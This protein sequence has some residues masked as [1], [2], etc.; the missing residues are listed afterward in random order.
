MFARYERAKA[1]HTN[2]LESFPLFIAAI[3]AGTVVGL[4]DSEMNLVAALILGSRMAYNW[5]YIS[6]EGGALHW[7]RTGVWLGHLLICWWVLVQA[8]LKSM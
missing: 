4:S 6:V 7:A 8:G 3:L 5:L 1:A 2:G